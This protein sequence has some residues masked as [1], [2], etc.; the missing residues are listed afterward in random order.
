MSASSYHLFF[1]IVAFEATVL[2][3][4]EFKLLA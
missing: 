4:S 3:D 1:G 2:Y